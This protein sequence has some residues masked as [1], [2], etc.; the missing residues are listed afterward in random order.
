MYLLDTV[1]VSALRRRDRNPSVA[2][3]VAGKPD[4]DLFISAVT[5]GEIER[6]IELRR[7]QDPTFAADLTAW[8]GRLVAIYGDSILPFDLRTARRCGRLS[9]AMGNA[10]ADLMI[11]ATALENGLLVVTRNV[12]DFAPTGVRTVN[13]FV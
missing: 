12:S 9:A 10:G 13:P 1:V 2:A 4:G 6:G 5:I 7:K 3:W 11:A 8:V